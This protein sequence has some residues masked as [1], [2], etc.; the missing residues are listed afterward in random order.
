[1]SA[2]ITQGRFAPEKSATSTETALPATR[3]GQHVGGTLSGAFTAAIGHAPHPGQAQPKSHTG[4]DA[5]KPVSAASEK[6]PVKNSKPGAPSLP[7]KGH[8]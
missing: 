2:R 1:M 3:S 5:L 7:R 4:A 8:R 6:T